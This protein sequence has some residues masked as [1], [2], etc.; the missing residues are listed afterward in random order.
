PETV[1]NHDYMVTKK[2]KMGHLI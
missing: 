2:I 1:H